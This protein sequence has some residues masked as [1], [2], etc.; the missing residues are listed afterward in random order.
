MFPGNSYLCI[1]IGTSVTSCLRASQVIN[2][3]CNTDPEQLSEAQRVLSVLLESGNRPEESTY[4]A[5]IRLH[6]AEGDRIRNYSHRNSA[7]PSRFKGERPHKLQAYI[8]S[9]RTHHMNAKSTLLLSWSKLR[10]SSCHVHTAAAYLTLPLRCA[11][12]RHEL[13]LIRMWQGVSS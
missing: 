6:I 9:P 4:T 8:D 2:L 1:E 7:R 12:M 10:L 3:C 5:F 13:W 11:D